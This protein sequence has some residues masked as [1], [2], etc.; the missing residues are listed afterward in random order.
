MFL[1]KKYILF[2]VN[3][4]INSKF[5]VWTM[6]YPYIINYDLSLYYPLNHYYYPYIIKWEGSQKFN[7]RDNSVSECNLV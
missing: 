3:L 7:G 5:I 6:N 2:K 4:W 1:E